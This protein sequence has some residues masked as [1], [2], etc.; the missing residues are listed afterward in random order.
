MST[1]VDRFTIKVGNRA[2]SIQ[3]QLFL[4]TVD[5]TGAT[6][7]FHMRN[8][9]GK[10]IVDQAG[11][12]DNIST[13][14]VSYDWQAGDTDTAGEYFGEFEVTYSDTKKETFPADAEIPI[15][16]RPVIA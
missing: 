14:K 15:T 16:V 8:K 5:L 10:V 13:R 6:V 1:N 3:Y 7:R 2:P 12:V 4:T 9:A 11:N